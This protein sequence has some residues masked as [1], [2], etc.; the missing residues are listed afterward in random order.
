MQ[1]YA[2][3]LDADWSIEETIKVV[4]FL[5]AVEQVFETSIYLD[6]FT[7]KYQRFKEVVT[8]I[9]QEKKIDREFQVLTGFSTYRAIQK[10][11]EMNKEKQGGNQKMYIK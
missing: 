2:Y 6:E 8:S 11:K 4:E 1:N 5:A 3:P 9:S 10:M 7:T